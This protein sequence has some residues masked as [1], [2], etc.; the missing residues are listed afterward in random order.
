LPP[1]P[2]R[3]NHHDLRPHLGGTVRQPWLGEISSGTGDPQRHARVGFAS[4]SQTGPDL[5][6]GCGPGA[7]TWFL[8]R[9]G[10]TVAGID[11]SASAIEQNRSRLQQEGLSAD[12][13]VGDITATLPWADASF[14]LVLDN[15]AL[16]ANPLPAI[17]RGIAEVARVLKPGGTFLHLSFTDRSWGYGEGRSAGAPGAYHEVDA[18]PLAHRGFVQFLARTDLDRL[19]GGFTGLQIERTSYTLENGQRQIEQWVAVCSKPGT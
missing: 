15:V 17:A 14:D 1:I 5:D 7:N 16:Y 3:G 12:L 4:R 19:L 10:F 11:G 9:E 2:R 13:H 18:G 6:L 8:A